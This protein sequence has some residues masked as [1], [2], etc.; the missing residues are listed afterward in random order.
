MIFTET[1]GHELGN[2][3]KASTANIFHIFAILQLEI[4]VKENAIH[5]K[6]NFGTRNERSSGASMSTGSKGEVRF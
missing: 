1:F 4:S 6:I 2:T 3:K 5:D